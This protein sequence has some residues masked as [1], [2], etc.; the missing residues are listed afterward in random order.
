MSN[1]V[2]SGNGDLLRLVLVMLLDFS[3]VSGKLP[4]NQ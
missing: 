2:L 1:T 3:V 4:E